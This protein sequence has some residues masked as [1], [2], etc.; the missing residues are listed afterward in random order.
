M[1]SQ[2][3]SL[4]LVVILASFVIGV[5]GSPV[6]AEN[7]DPNDDDSQRAYAENV[8]WI[9]AEPSGDGGPG[10]QVDDFE[11]TG[12]MWGENIGWI[13]LSCQNTASCGTTAYSVINDGVG[14]FRES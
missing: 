3:N 5:C 8:G 9:N 4:F 2:R 11:L 14:V 12:W 7:I 10:I 1:N 13:S 6:L